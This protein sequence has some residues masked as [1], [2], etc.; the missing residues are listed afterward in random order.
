MLKTLLGHTVQELSVSQAAAMPGVLYLDARELPEY[1][2]SHLAGARWVGYDS[3]DLKSVAD[4][5]RDTALVIYCSVGYRSEKVTEKLLQAGFTQ[6]SNLYGGIFEWVNERRPI[7]D[8]QG[9]P[10]EKL[11]AYSPSWG[12]WVA[13]GEKV[14]E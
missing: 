2:V 3:F 10:T 6:V 4:L 1:Q 13:H 14:Y 11:H 8:M 5:P 9:A 7:V 12:V